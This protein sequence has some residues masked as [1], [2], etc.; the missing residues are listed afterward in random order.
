MPASIVGAEQQPAPGKDW[1]WET[2]TGVSVGS[3]I[4]TGVCEA[5]GEMDVG[6]VVGTAVTAI[7][8]PWQLTIINT[9][10]RFAITV[11]VIIMFFYPSISCAARVSRDTTLILLKS[12]QPRQV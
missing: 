5:D 12:S 3:E 1:N 9:N 6:V 2:G 4:D 10:A 8:L 11:L 7:G